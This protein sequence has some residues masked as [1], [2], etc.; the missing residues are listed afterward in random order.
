MDLKAFHSI[1]KSYKEWAVY[2]NKH[3]VG[4][5]PARNGYRAVTPKLDME[6]AEAAPFLVI[7]SISHS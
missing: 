6:K 2:Q 7:C 3:S 4:E 5:P 1:S